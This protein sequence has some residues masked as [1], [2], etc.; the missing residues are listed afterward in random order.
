M[1]TTV[2]LAEDIELAQG[3]FGRVATDLSLIL[4]HEIVL[5]E[6]HASREDQRAAGEGGVHISFKLGINVSGRTLQGCLLVPLPMAVTLAAYMM[7]LPDATVAQE[8]LR[9]ELDPPF[10]EALLEVGKFLAGA[11]DTVLRRRLGFQVT[12]RSEGCQGVRAGVR[13]ALAYREGDELIVARAT[14]RVHDF[15]PCTVVLM[16]PVIE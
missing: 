2:L 14:A 11:C 13:P 15:E 3:V 10:K 9:T 7:M 4:D 6:V 1:N 5:D 12:T 16:L 8:R